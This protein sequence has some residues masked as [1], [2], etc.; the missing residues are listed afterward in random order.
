MTQLPLCACSLSA[1]SV[2]ATNPS[3]HGLTGTRPPSRVG[4]PS[5]EVVAAGAKKGR[6]SCLCKLAARYYVLSERSPLAS[7]A[8]AA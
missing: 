6:E 8:P 7:F 1:V 5:R 4:T 2:D 3:N